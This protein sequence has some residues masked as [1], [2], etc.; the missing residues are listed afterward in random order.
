MKNNWFKR[1]GWFYLP[2]STAGIVLSLLGLAFCVQVF[3]AIDRHSHSV[4]DTVY[5]IFPY[6]GCCFLLMNW[7]ASNTCRANEDKAV[8]PAINPR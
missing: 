2:V 6:F 4:S 1:I 7:I 5:G 3:L 8:N